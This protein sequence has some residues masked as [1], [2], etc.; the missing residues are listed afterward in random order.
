M[1]ITITADLITAIEARYNALGGD[2]WGAESI[3]ARARY[4]LP[5]FAGSTADFVELVADELRFD[6]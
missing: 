2:Y 3:E 6:D 5:G 4:C 1:T